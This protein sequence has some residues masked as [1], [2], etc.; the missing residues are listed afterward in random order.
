MT[1]QQIINK[2]WT[3]QILFHLRNHNKQLSYKKIKQQLNIPNSTLA[4]RLTELTKYKYLDKFIYGSVSKPHYTEYKITN[5]G[6][7]YINS[8][9]SFVTYD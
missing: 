3:I 4:I 9:F 1:E 2:K 6:I 8:V 7:Q 5:L